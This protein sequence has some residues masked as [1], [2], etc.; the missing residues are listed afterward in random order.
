MCR[1]FGAISPGGVDAETP[2]FKAAHPFKDFSETN[3]DGWGMGWYERRKPRIFKE[4][5]DEMKK[6]HFERVRGIRSPVM[7][8]HVRRIQPGENGRRMNIDAQPFSCGDYIFA[9]NGDADWKNIASRLAPETKKRLTSTNE[10]EMFMMLIM[11]FVEGGMET[12][13]AIGTA[14]R[15]AK[16]TRYTALNFLLSDCKHIYAYRDA[17]CNKGW[18]SL[19]WTR[20]DGEIWLSSEPIMD[21][22]WNDLEMGELV[23]A[24]MDLS[25]ESF[26]LD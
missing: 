13:E 22:K 20:R 25:V 9:H 4:G 1:L 18:F 11:Q 26:R 8:A 12:V 17:S 14:V 21:G 23:R 15:A 19:C 5:A 24:G 10:S 2:F 16:E 3:R 6:Y 7:I